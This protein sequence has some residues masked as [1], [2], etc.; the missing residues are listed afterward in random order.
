MYVY[1]DFENMRVINGDDDGSPLKK[2]AEVIGKSNPGFSLHTLWVMK[3]KTM[4]TGFL[5]S[6]F[7]F[8]PLVLGIF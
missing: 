2:I 8:G 3:P 7:V 1:L 4:A 5:D 6:L